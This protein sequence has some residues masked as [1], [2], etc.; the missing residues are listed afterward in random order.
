MIEKQQLA[1]IKYKLKGIVLYFGK[2]AS[3]LCGGK[4]DEKNNN[5]ILASVS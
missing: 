5:F 3:W 1:A 2:Y 4:F